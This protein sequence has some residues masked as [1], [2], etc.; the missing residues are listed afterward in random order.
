M[1]DFIKKVDLKWQLSYAPHYQFDSNGDCYNTRSGRQIKRT[2][3][4][5]TE[6]YC[7]CGRFRSLVRLRECLERIEEIPF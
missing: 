5:Y 4:G 3:V 6:G 1:A 7:I 2:V